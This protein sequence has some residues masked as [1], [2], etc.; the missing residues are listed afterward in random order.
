MNAKQVGNRAAQPS[1][2]GAPRRGT[3]GKQLLLLGLVLAALAAGVWRWMQSSAAKPP[4]FAQINLAGADPSLAGL[5]R[6]ARDAAMS[7]P[8]SPLAWGQLA[9]ICHANGFSQ[10]AL[11]AYDTA[12]EL[13]PDNWHWPYLAGCLHFEGPGGPSAALP[14]FERAV[15]LSPPRSMAVIRLADALLELDQLDRAESRYRDLLEDEPTAPFAHLGLARLAIVR[16]DMQEAIQHLDHIVQH[17]AVQL[18]AS[19]T[20]ASALERMGEYL[21]A[22]R[23]RQRLRQLPGDRFRL[24]DPLVQ[25]LNF[26]MGVDRELR[27]ADAHFQAGNLAEGRQALRRVVE[28]YPQSVEAWETLAHWCG[29]SGDWDGAVLACRQCIQLAPKSAESH[30]ALGKA[31]YM[32]R[33]YE[34]S[35]AA[36]QQAIALDP[37]SGSAYLALGECRDKLNDRAG[38]EAAFRQAL[39]YLSDD[40]EARQRVE[41]R[42]ANP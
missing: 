33:Q 10:A 14:L 19:A 35:S 38:A 22:R 13:E 12:A 1:A 6:E 34:A 27:Q 11:A 41:S 5:V 30:L 16:G 31:L 36:L 26:E 21:A 7:N 39:R 4:Q 2:A 32:S 24:D 3:R 40:P 20:R 23:E 17:P 25:I 37:Q 29:V 42:L 15:S 9:M 8:Q 28:Q 18:Q